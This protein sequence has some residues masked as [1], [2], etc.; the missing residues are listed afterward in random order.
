MAASQRGH[1]QKKGWLSS[2]RAP[3]AQGRFAL[4]GPGPSAQRVTGC[5]PNA[6][7]GARVCWHLNPS[8]GSRQGGGAHPRSP[9]Q[10][11]VLSQLPGGVRVLSQ[12]R[13]LRRAGLPGLDMLAPSKGQE[14]KKPRTPQDSQC[15]PL[16]PCFLSSESSK[17]PQ[18]PQWLETVSGETMSPFRRENEDTEV[19]DGRETLNAA[20]AGPEASPKAASQGRAAAR[21]RTESSRR[22]PASKGCHPPTSQA[23]YA[24][25]PG[26][27]SWQKHP[28]PWSGGGRAREVC[29]ALGH[30]HTPPVPFKSQAAVRRPGDPHQAGPQLCPAGRPWDP[31]IL[32][33]LVQSAGFHPSF[34][35]TSCVPLLEA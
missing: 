2:Q 12:S 32:H 27:P 25:Q 9:S 35:S 14:P 11:P 24:P 19:D 17:V 13:N 4:H 26:F 1:D 10:T 29:W 28:G 20:E 3:L 16:D 8:R 21:G 30:S 31:F 22:S 6:G 34:L 7:Q 15:R 18:H 33:L 5:A 23:N